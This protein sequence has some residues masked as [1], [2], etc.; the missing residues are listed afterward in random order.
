MQKMEFEQTVGKAQK[1]C[2]SVKLLAGAAVF[3]GLALGVY[4][5]VRAFQKGPQLSL[6]DPQVK[7]ATIPIEGMTCASCVARVKKTLKSIDGV[8]EVE[9]SLE[10]RKARVQY[11]DTKVSLEGLAAA[12]NDLGYRAGTPTEEA[13]R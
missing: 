6:S 11:L 10:H 7:T 13:P 9:V 3:L 12:V 4:L 5:L 2:R 8:M 1:I